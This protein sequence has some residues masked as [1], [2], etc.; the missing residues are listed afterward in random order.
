MTLRRKII[1]FTASFLATVLVVVGGSYRI[2]K[3]LGENLDLLSSEVSK[4]KQHD[5]L[6]L[7]V[8][9]IVSS[10]ESWVA[11]GNPAHRDRLLNG[12][13][14]AQGFAGQLESIYGGRAESGAI[15]EDLEEMLLHARNISEIADP[16]VSAEAEESLGYLKSY[17]DW[18]LDRTSHLH[19]D[20]MRLTYE[21]SMESERAKGRVKF[22]LTLIVAFAL[23]ST[24]FLLIVMKRVLERPYSEMLRATEKVS[25][26]DLSYR[27]RSRGEDEF[28][29]ISGRFDD[30][31]ENLE[32]S[33]RELKRKLRETELFLSVARISGMLADRKAVLDLMTE[34]IAGKMGKDV[35]AILLYR[36]DKEAFC[37]ESCNMKEAVS[38]RLLSSDTGLSKALRETLK[39]VII[40]RA[41][42]FPEVATLCPRTASWLAVPILREQSCIGVLMLG[43]KDA[44]GFREDEK[45]A[46]MILS[47]T[48]GATIR[49]TE[50]YEETRKQLRQLGIV[51]ELS[52]TLTSV[53][54]PE[55]M[56]R[57]I[58]ARIASLLS[59]R[60][61]V[62]RT[63]EGDSLRI[64]SSYGPAEVYEWEQDVAV[65]QG[66]AG[67]VA[68][69]G[70]PL[71]VE[72]FSKMPEEVQ[73]TG[74]KAKSA[75][76]VPLKKDE[77]IVGTL[78]L[79]DRLKEG[80]EIASFTLDDLALAEAMASISAVA[81]EKV[82]MQ[83]LE[84][85]TRAEIIAAKR[86]MELLFE[87]VQGGIVTLDRSFTIIAANQYAERWIDLPHREL[88]GR[89]AFEVFHEKGGICPHCA[90]KATF[91]DGSTNTITQSSGL[92]YADLAA[93]PVKDDEGNVVEAVV[94]I[95][96]ITERVL[97]QEEIMGLYREVMQ[98]KEYMEALI[99]NSADAIVTSDLDGVVK[100]WN[101]A[102]EAIY[103]FTKEE[104][105]GKYLPFVPE[106]LREFEKENIEKIKAGEVVKLETFRKRKDG[107]TI[108]VSLTLSPIKDVTGEIIGISGI[109]RD[110]TDKRRVE[111]ELI[112]RNQELSRLFFISSA[113]RGTL[114][115]DRLLRM[116]LTAVTMGDGLGFNRAILFLVDEETHTLKGTMGVGPS[117][118]EEA[119]KI[120]GDLSLEKRRLPDIMREIEE[121]PKSVESFLHRLS[122]G[123]E[124][125]LGDDTI[126]TKTAWEKKSFNIPDV[127]AEPYADI[128]LI[129]QL[130]TESF[131]T[132]PLVSR[133]NVMGVLWVDNKFNRKPITEEDMKFLAGFANQVASA[134]EAARLFRKVSLAE[135]ELENIFRSISDM[136]FF[137]DKDYTVKNVNRAVEDRL[138]RPREDIVGRKCYEVFHGMEEPWQKCP[139]HKT[140]ETMKHFVEE[141]EDLHMN[142]TFITS[143]APMFD[144]EGR[145]QGTVHV[146]RDI[147][148][149]KGLRVKLQSAERM[150]ALGEVAAKVAHEIRNP[151]VSIGGFAKRLEEK[152]EGGL[153]EYAHIILE[154]VKRLESILK[155][156]L[157][158]VKEVR[159]SR[160]SVDLNDI[161]QGVLD[162]MGAEFQVKGNRVSKELSEAS[163]VMM[164]DPDRVKEAIFNIVSNA[165][166]ATDGGMIGV[167]TFMQNGDGVV[168]ISDTG[169]GIRKEDLER[170]FDPFFTTRPT[171]TGLGLAISKRIVEENEG[172]ITVDSRGPGQGTKFTIHLPLQEG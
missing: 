23:S 163:V 32:N 167:K 149:L 159:L 108:E 141:L 113:M 29:L 85:K 53:Y 1:I 34:T 51:Y 168:E 132:V 65:G 112:R 156:I 94:F 81:I 151:L 57:T 122:T 73:Q 166:Q 74:T 89:N 70:R 71:F 98:T 169:Y 31:V 171:G 30:M 109:S 63:M 68:R 64:R 138:G 121:G 43:M 56:L 131:A 76:G 128:L 95:Q 40:N 20:S 165:N 135:A 25:S 26:G 116:V 21:I 139:H 147:T 145:F 130:G 134:I 54:E 61:C 3:T 42:D 79:Y 144:A 39:P 157:G 18:L 60:G 58:S 155:D 69:E 55:E 124:I 24:A 111:N 119:W 48:I 6:S 114:E 127:K 84:R 78:V 140:V 19:R 5:E 22:Y 158:F 102:A 52:K 28:G 82:R 146:A 137:T 104:V 35:C 152:L 136:V 13:A 33:D 27:I 92:N 14:L 129:Q 105:A 120:W 8:R 161:V 106:S 153:R 123:I 88:V 77:R 99:N 87:S 150:A 4:H 9:N 90:A 100:S 37:L 86:R 107:A 118:P 83:E 47:H 38:D 142:G 97:Y 103:G 15:R 2:F 7:A 91:E 36:A 125:P 101:P 170:I 133:D 45:D 12:I 162:L 154:E 96:D 66:I 10:A 72:D 49:N 160:K 148:E 93:Y 172:S 41:E 46:A 115:L 16:T 143:T 62:I 75:I 80:G 17:E 44:M 117:S 126:L 110:I 67:W 11:T 59:A 164:V 50:L